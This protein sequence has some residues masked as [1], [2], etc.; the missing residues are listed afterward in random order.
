MPFLH[1]LRDDC[2]NPR[3]Y[4]PAAD[5]RLLLQHAADAIAREPGDDHHQRHRGAGPGDEETLSQPLGLGGHS[6][7]RALSYRG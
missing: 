6:G 3:G 7:G 5:V 2:G 1:V 4:I